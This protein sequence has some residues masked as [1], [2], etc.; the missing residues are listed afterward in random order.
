MEN[1][2]EI[3]EAIKANNEMMLLNKRIVDFDKAMDSFKVFYFGYLDEYEDNILKAICSYKK[4]ASDNTTALEIQ[5]VITA[6][7]NSH[8]DELSRLI[9]EY[10][11]KIKDKM[12]L[13]DDNEYRKELNQMMLVIVNSISEFCTENIN[14]LIEECVKGE[15]EDT[16]KK[17]TNYL[18]VIVYGKLINTLRDNFSYSIRIIDNNHEENNRRMEIINQK[19]LNRV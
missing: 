19:T 14:M 17:I 2:I 15:D 3:K 9:D 13:L 11:S 1:E 8:K 4:I 6:F 7:V 18:K 12:P 10:G 5:Q 16:N